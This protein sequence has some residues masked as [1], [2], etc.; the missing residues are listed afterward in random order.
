[1]K[2][3]LKYFL[4]MMLLI[5]LGCSPKNTDKEEVLCRINDYTLPVADFQKQLAEELEFEKDFK[6]TQEAK[7][8]FLDNII[9]KEILIQEA[10]K[11]GLDQ[12]EKFMRAIERYWESTLIRDLMDLKNKEIAA[13]TIVSEDEI[14]GRYQQLIPNDKTFSRL[15]EMRNTIRETLKEEKRAAVFHKWIVELKKKADIEINENLL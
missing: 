9:E 2:K 4:A 15:D 1:M 7:R 8:E 5:S 12:K 14:K 11:Q 10:K 13:R 3:L 6:L